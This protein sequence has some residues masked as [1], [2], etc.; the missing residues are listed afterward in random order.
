[1]DLTLTSS[2]FGG[3]PFADIGIDLLALAVV[4]LL[5]TGVGRAEP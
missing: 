5:L 1:M 2:C 3:D 4:G